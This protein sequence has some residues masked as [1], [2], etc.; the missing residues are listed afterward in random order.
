M[1]ISL[2][3]SG[4]TQEYADGVAPGRGVRSTAPTGLRRGGAAGRGGASGGGPPAGADRG[5]VI[6]RSRV[7]VSTGGVS[8]RGGAAGGSMIRA[9]NG[10][11]LS[12]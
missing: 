11:A 12:R 4:G 7:V 8:G 3:V 5:A 6:G 2:G 10:A 9:A 1:V